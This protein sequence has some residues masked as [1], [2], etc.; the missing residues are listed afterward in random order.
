MYI[1]VINVSVPG[2]PPAL[3]LLRTTQYALSMVVGTGSLW[4]L[5]AHQPCKRRVPHKLHNKPQMHRL[6]PP[7][8]KTDAVLPPTL[9]Q[10]LTSHELGGHRVAQ[11]RRDCRELCMRHPSLQVRPA[12]LACNSSAPSGAR[13]RAREGGVVGRRGRGA[14]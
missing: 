14:A 12:P 8:P 7:T 9:L 4:G 3:N 11:L 2:L 5:L 6:R 10:L 1:I 13:R